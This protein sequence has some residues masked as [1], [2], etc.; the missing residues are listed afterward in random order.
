[1]P[2]RLSIARAVV[3]DSAPMHRCAIMFNT[4]S[5]R[6]WHLLCM[7]IKHAGPPRCYLHVRM[8]YIAQRE[9]RAPP[10]E[11]LRVWCNRAS[12]APPP[13][14]RVRHCGDPQLIMPLKY[15]PGKHTVTHVFDD[16]KIR[17]ARPR[18]APSRGL[19]KYPKSGRGDVCTS[20]FMCPPATGCRA[21]VRSAACVLLAVLRAQGFPCTRQN[22]HGQRRQVAKGDGIC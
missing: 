20:V 6:V 9:A 7:C 16:H 12:R 22:A 19:T 13:P 18:N 17:V 3:A 10:R 15:P 21:R 2:T 1:M 8:L 4:T 5:I 11:R 14:P